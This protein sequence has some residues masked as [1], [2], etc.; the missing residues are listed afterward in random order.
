MVEQSGPGGQAG[1]SKKIENYLG[2]PAGISGADLARRAADQALRFGAEVLTQEVS[3]L[4]R[5]DPYRIVRLADGTDVSSKAVLLATGVSVR[6]L[7][8]PG[9]EP[10]VGNGVYYGAAMSE[11]S[12]FRAKD[13]CV[14]GAGNSA[15]Q[16]ALYFSRHARRV[17]VLVRGDSL[18]KSMSRY[19]IDRI[20][21]EENIE[22]VTKAEVTGVA[23]TRRL[24]RVN[25]RLPESGEERAFDAA[26]MYIFIGAKPRTEMFAGTIELD[27]KGYVLT[28][29]DLPRINQRPRGWTLDRDP[30]LFE[31]SVPG[32]FAAGDVRGGS[33]KRVAAAVG[34]GSAA[35]SMI[36]RYLETV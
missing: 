27:E 28:G 10:L 36:H 1:T 2:F 4:R 9:L 34:E 12:L 17:T 33:G 6:M 18:E 5:E 20:R 31:T 24:E 32:V 11:A 14:V 8:V 29:P 19:L 16:G 7:K 22:V 26:A 25:V 35:V 21:K 23:G 15:G 3:S 13:V 30:Y